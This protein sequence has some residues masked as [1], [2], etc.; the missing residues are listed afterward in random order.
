MFVGLVRSISEISKRIAN[1]GI[2]LKEEE[3]EDQEDQEEATE[4]ITAAAMAEL[5]AA[6]AGPGIFFRFEKRLLI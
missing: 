2:S 5:P 4:E 1:S 6:Q 3:K